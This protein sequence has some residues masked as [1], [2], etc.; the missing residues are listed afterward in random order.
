MT[1]KQNEEEHINSMAD[2][3]VLGLE[4]TLEELG[5]ELLGKVDGFSTKQLRKVLKAHINFTS[6]KDHKY[7]HSPS[8][9][10][11][12][13]ERVLKFL[14]GL[15]ALHEASVQYAIYILGQVQKEQ[16]EKSKG[17]N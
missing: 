15:D 6:T 8:Y 12:D 5:E 16:D 7:E 1:N 2:N 17:G 3:I 9:S 14:A 4:R 11:Q 10:E 13:K